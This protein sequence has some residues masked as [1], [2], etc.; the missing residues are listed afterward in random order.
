[1]VKRKDVTFYDT[2]TNKGEIPSI[3]LT[4]DIFYAAFSFDNLKLIILLLMR[5]YIQF[6]E[7]I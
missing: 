2:N 7:N 1:M 4:K 5:E 6:L 3:K